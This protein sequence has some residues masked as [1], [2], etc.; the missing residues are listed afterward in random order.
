M[1]K[2]RVY[3]GDEHIITIKVDWESRKKLQKLAL[4]KDISTSLYASKVIQKHVN[5][6]IP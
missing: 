5:D 4:E 2:K 1:S 3:K 6:L